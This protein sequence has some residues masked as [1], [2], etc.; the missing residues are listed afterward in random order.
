MWVALSSTLPRYTSLTPIALS[1]FLRTLGSKSNS[2]PIYFNIKSIFLS[3]ILSSIYKLYCHIGYKPYT[4]QALE[5]FTKKGP[6]ERHFSS[7]LANFDKNSI[8]TTITVLLLFRLTGI[9]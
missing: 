5:L 1:D 9:W 2:L 4:H 7:T 3:G 6:S 8:A